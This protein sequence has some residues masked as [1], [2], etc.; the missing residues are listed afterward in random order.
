MR[1]M[2]DGTTW[3]RFDMGWDTPNMATPQIRREIQK[4][5]KKE[6]KNKKK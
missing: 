4:A 6:R 3:T 2:P 1:D 5:R